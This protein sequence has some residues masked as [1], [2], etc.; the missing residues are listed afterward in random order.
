[1]IFRILF[2][3]FCFAAAGTAAAQEFR[4]A[5]E[6]ASARSEKA[7]VV[8]KQHMVVA[9]EPLAAEAGRQILR[10][11]G[12]ATDAAIATE[13]VLGLV[14]PQS[15]GLGGGAFITFWDAK[16]RSV[17]TYDGRETAP[18]TAKPDRFMRD[19]K[20]M[21][22]EDAVNSGL[23]VGVPGL[24]RVLHEVH[25][26]YGKLPWAK[27]FEPAIK[28]AEDGFAV[29]P[30]L[31]TLL[32]SEKPEKFTA[33]A[34]AYFFEGGVTPRAAGS[35]L[36]NPEY[37]AT[38]RTIAERGPDAFYSGD[39][40]DAMVKAV[41]EAP[42][43]PGDLSAADLTAYKAKEREPVCFAYRGRQ[44]CGMGPPSSGA[45]TVGAVLKLIEPYRQ[46]QGASAAMTAPA[47]HIIAEAEK[48]AFADRNKYIADPD[49]I[50]VPSG[51][52]DDAYLAERRKLIDPK[53]AMAK[54]EPGLPPGLAKKAFGK[55]ATYEV[56]G[57]TQVSII[58]DEGN[59][60]SMTAT[61]ESAF[62]SHL[63]A[64]GFLLNNELTDFS[65]VPV[66]A[67]GVTVANAIEGGK[68]PRSSMAPTI[69]LGQD[70]TPEIVTGSPGGSQI[71][72]YVVKTLLAVLDWGLDAQQAAALANFGSQGG[73]FLIEYSL[74]IV[75]P[76]YELTSYGQAVSGATMTSGVNMIVK[77]NGV[78]D[79][80]ADPRREGVAL[81]D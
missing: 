73:P 38:L 68:R 77:R 64:K 70:G 67:T 2:V 58:D 76:A 49:R 30:R 24:L 79:G 8:A 19:G 80:G 75:W 26:K 31:A 62:G 32:K 72:L 56:P 52:L 66:D 23:S 12:S 13:L 18:A 11:G 35:L 17:T 16:S 78:L 41:K 60:L 39:I 5:P 48:L 81:G 65:F 54:A 44:V 1:M 6:G 20:P 4:P 22:F 14:E 42:T 43:I 63:W 57:T 15:S 25:E 34:R 27:L 53:K 47:L 7:L 46:V 45:L 51:L 9:A 55:D 3:I 50:A 33:D 61:I 40:A 59:A 29:S 28:L 10:Q 69:V 74:P 37:A 21:P 71:I 36:K